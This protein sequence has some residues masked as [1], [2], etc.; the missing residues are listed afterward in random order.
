MTFECSNSIQYRR[1][2]RSAFDDQLGAYGLLLD[3][4]WVLFMPDIF[5]GVYAS[6]PIFTS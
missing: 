4:V 5:S 6:R 3:G 1:Q 2:H